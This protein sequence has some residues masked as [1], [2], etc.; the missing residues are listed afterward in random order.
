MLYEFLRK[1]NTFIRHIGYICKI[2]KVISTIF[3][4]RYMKCF[5]PILHTAWKVSVFGVILVRIFPHSDTFLR[6]DNFLE[7][8]KK[9]RGNIVCTSSCWGEGW[10]GGVEHSTK[11]FKKGGLTGSQFLE[12]GCWERGLIF[13]GVLQLLYKKWTNIWNI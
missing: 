5:Q 9:E 13:L 12:R 6:S 8:I 11:F 1:F 4:E 2:R 3:E 10:E 7:A